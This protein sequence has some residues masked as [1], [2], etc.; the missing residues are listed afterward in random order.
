MTADQINATP[1]FTMEDE[2]DESSPPFAGIIIQDEI[3]TKVKED[4]TAKESWHYSVRP[5]NYSI[6][7]ATGAWHT[8]CPLSKQHASIMQQV[9]GG[10]VV[11][12][13]DKTVGLPFKSVFGRKPDGSVYNIGRGELVGLVGMWQRRNLT[14]VNKK[15][16][17]TYTSEGVLFLTGPASAEDTAK[18]KSLPAVGSANSAEQVVER[19]ESLPVDQV[20]VL[21][22]LIV[23]NTS[24]A[25][26][27]TAALS[28]GLP[29]D[30]IAE[31]SNG[32]AHRTLV[33]AGIIAKGE[34]GRYLWVNAPVG[35][36]A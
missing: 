11:D 19:T 31:L 27:L 10:Y 28:R 22:E 7:G 6:G 14:F 1:V 5:V 35:A 20:E 24:T 12:S 8:Y 15:A 17:T 13:G 21:A 3:S 36:E 32:N 30:V 26:A 16:G 18:A 29:E 4:G 34:G 23:G 9:L 25:K 33:E 2:A